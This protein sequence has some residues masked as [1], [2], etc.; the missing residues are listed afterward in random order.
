LP[1]SA[2]RSESIRMPASSAKTVTGM[3]FMTTPLP[4][5]R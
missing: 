2:S 4:Q 1:A 3:P 5:Q